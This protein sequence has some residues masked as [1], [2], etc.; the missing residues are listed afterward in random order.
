MSH[1][2]AFAPLQEKI[3]QVSDELDVLDPLIENTNERFIILDNFFQ[4][5]RK[6]HPIVKYFKKD[7]LSLNSENW[8]WRRINWK[9]SILKWLNSHMKIFKTPVL[10]S[11]IP[12]KCLKNIVYSKTEKPIFGV[13]FFLIILGIIFYSRK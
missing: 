5:I 6:A 12:T 13:F 1:L 3:N 9:K 10:N 7:T 8:I 4:I 2:D 11:K